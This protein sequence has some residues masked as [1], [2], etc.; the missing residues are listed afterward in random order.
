MGTMNEVGEGGAGTDAGALAGGAATPAAVDWPGCSLLGGDR[1]RRRL[2]WGR[3]GGR[4]G[5]GDVAAAAGS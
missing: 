1:R 5:G 3:G 4:G 2:G